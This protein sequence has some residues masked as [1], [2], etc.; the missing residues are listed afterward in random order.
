M[1]RM[2]LTDC[3]TGLSGSM[4]RGSSMNFQVS[5]SRIMSGI[6]RKAIRGGA[7]AASACPAAIPGKIIAFS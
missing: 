2:P 4:A 6:W 1:A 5:P 3:T 7:A